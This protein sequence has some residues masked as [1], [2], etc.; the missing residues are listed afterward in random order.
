MLILYGRIVILARRIVRSDRARLASTSGDEKR[1]SIQNYAES[2]ETD[3][4]NSEDKTCSTS[5]CFCS[6][7]C[8]LFE[9][10]QSLDSTDKT[11]QPILYTKVN[12][13]HS[14]STSPKVNFADPHTNRQFDSPP[15]IHHFSRLPPTKCH[16]QSTIHRNT[17]NNPENHSIGVEFLTPVK[18]D[19]NDPFI[20]RRTSLH[21]VNYRG[22][23]SP[24][25]RGRAYSVGVP[26]V[27]TKGA[28]SSLLFFS[29][30]R[31]SL[32][33]HLKRS[34]IKRSN[35]AK[36]IRTLGVI[37][38]VFCICWLPFFIVAVS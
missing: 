37:M 13:N 16:P 10:R 20:D 34:G 15:V 1:N 28:R 27:Q 29:K 11:L 12:K 6:S 3:E 17:I 9:K 24:L 18:Q 21:Q 2:Q 8:H 32:A 31:I 7:C 36:A 5:S 25:L 22:R 4:G 33:L 30:H 35:E 19:P 26:S 23:R 14:N 38:G